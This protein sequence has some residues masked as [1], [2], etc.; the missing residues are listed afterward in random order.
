MTQQE[1]LELVSQELMVPVA[2]LETL[3]EAAAAAGRP[4]SVADLLA[5]G[6]HRDEHPSRAGGSAMS[7]SQVGDRGGF[8]IWRFG[9]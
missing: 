9:K 7:P 5:V 2:D 8:R 4:L 6:A 1:R 3:V